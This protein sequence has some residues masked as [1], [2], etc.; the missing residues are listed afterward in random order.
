MVSKKSQTWSM[1][2]LF[3]SLIFIGLFILI[4][5]L[6]FNKLTDI[7]TEQIFIK[8]E[9]VDKY[10]TISDENEYGFLTPQ[11]IID[12]QR[13]MKFAN[14]TLDEEDYESLKKKLN[15][16]YDFCVF[17]ENSQ[18]EIRPIVLSNGS[19][20]YG[21]GNNELV[22]GNDTDGVVIRCGQLITKD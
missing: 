15:L 9:D 8:T 6:T 21:M 7:E 3:A 22:L 13:M 14:M 19:Y 16:D 1:D 2:I 4:Y 20:L 18:G 11:N 17:F 12:V 10:F 5:F